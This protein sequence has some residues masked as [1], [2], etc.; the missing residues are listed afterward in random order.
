MAALLDVDGVRALLAEWMP[1]QRWFAAKGRHSALRI[2]TWWDLPAVP[3]DEAVQV[4]TFLVADDAA[5]PVALYQVPLVARPDASVPPGSPNAVGSPEPGWTL[6]DGAHDPAFATA[7]R[8]L[9][10]AGGSGT[11]PGSEAHGVPVL[12]APAT[13]RWTSDVLRGEQSN[14]SIIFRSDDAP[15]M[16][17]KIFRL[18][19]AGV[20]PD[21]ELQSGLAAAGSPFVPRA[22]G[23]VVGRWPSPDGTVEGSLAF[24]QEFLP[25][26]EDAWRVAL[27]AASSDRD[28]TASAHSLGVATASV[29]RTL[30]VTFPTV[31]ASDDD[32]R[33]IAVSWQRRLDVAIADVPELADLRSAIEAVYERA[34]QGPWP[35]LQRVHGD[36]HLGQAIL[37]PQRGWMLLDFEGEPLRPMTERV[38]PDLALR[39][40][41]GML[42]SFDYVAGSSRLTHP[43]LPIAPARDWANA[44][45]QAF[46][47]GYASASEVDLDAQRP[48]R[49]ALEL[50]KAVYEAVY[51]IRNRPDWLPVPV[52]GIRRLV[53]AV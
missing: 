50:D 46:L 11:G 27:R 10:T 12:P 18:L 7:L 3:G 6:L 39:D 47:A 29:H 15:P 20:N 24:A 13:G 8:R 52:L 34:Q 9:V 42:R 25:G 17:V 35:Q 51:E 36:L 32:R 19:H 1:R 38:R 33:R 5:V 23:H 45:R 37:A 53:R 40:V 4:R 41:A 2:V 49:D 30:A 14:T 26:V 31:D 44:A 22:L 16:I 28:F 48:L 43:D 21:I